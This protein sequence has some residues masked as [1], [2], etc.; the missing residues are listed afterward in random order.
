MK[1]H[2]LIC[3]I[4]FLIG[5]S[6]FS[7][8]PEIDWQITIGGSGSEYLT[9]SDCTSDGGLIV[10]G[11]SSSGISGNK[12]EPH[13]GNSDYWVVKLAA[14]GNITWQNTIGGTGT[15]NLND[16]QQTSDEGYILGGTS[17]STNNYDRIEPTMGIYDYWVIKLT[18]FGAIQW[19]NAIGGSQS[20]YL[21][22][23][24][25][26]SDGGFILGGTSNSGISGDKTQAQIGEDDFWIIKLNNLGGIVWQ[27]TIGGSLDD[28]LFMIRQTFD[29]GYIVGGFSDSGISGNKT[30]ASRGY[31]DY[32]I[33]KLDSVGSIEWQR[34]LGGSS[35]D[36][37]KSIQQT[38]DSGFIIGGYT[39][40]PIS[41]DLTDTGNGSYDYWIIK[42]DNAGNIEW[43]NMIGGSDADKLYSIEPTSDG[44]Y[45]LGG[46]SESPISGDK[47]VGAISVFEDY[48]IVKVDSNGTVLW[49]KTI[50]GYID[51]N[52]GLVKQTESGE[53]FVSGQSSSKALFDKTENSKGGIDY[54]VLKLTDGCDSVFYADLDNDGFGDSLNSIVACLNPIGYVID[55]SDCNDTDSGI[56]ILQEELCN[57]FDDNCNGLIDDDVMETISIFPGGPTTFC[58]GGSVL[59]TATFSGATVQW[60]RNG[61]NIPGATSPTYLVSTKGTYTS[62]TTSACD[63]ELSTSVFVNVQKNPPASITAGGA[64]T[65]CE[66]GFTNLIA[67]ETDA[68]YLW[69]NGEIN[70]SITV[71]TTG[72]LAE[73]INAELQ[74][75]QPD[76]LKIRM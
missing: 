35:N 4:L 64:T 47:T 46:D 7:Q 45:I 62:E 41:G 10:G 13:L 61:I 29:G 34:T 65:F 11:Y 53:Y 39:S 67:D 23:V 68:L 19:Q 24:S 75:L 3:F 52:I 40:S 12:N 42:L 32:W 50:I 63:T 1:N 36:N 27:T 54:W 33:I 51:D 17:G 57:D 49:D 28:D 15:E 76:V 14:T 69:S 66:G 31:G 37:L 55:N 25:Q 70:Q 74:K 16:V 43:Q 56:N 9:S 73:I 26:T 18:S 44:G 71:A 21:K 20:D 58:Q 48:W 22:S 30:E 8:I 5:T 59:L 2:I 38:L 72:H 60:K 6:S